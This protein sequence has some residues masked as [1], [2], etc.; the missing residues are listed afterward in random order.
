MRLPVLAAVAAAL[1]VTGVAGAAV[2]GVNDDAAKDTAQVGWL[3]PTLAGEGL[4]ESTLTLRWD[5]A[6]PAA[7]PDQAAV[8]RAVAAAAANGASVELDLFP[9]HSMAFT[10]GAKCASTTDPQGCG[11]TAQIQSFAVWAGQVA[12]AFPTVHQ[13]VVMNEC[14]QPLFVNPQFDATG[15]N[16]SAQIC[17]RA[18]AAAYDALKGVSSQNVVW[19]VGLSPRG[20]DNPNAASNVS[21]SPTKFLADLGAWYKASGRTRPLMD[22]LDFHPYPIPQSLPFATGYAGTTSA[23]VSNLPRIYQ[24]F[25]DAFN[26]SPQRTIG[27]QT[28]GG[29]P[30]SL[31]E[32]GIQTDSTGSPGY[33][34]TETAANAAG[35]VLGATATE[36]YQ[37]SWYSQMLQYVACDPN[38]TQV[39]IYHL[40]DESAL[41]GWQSGLF[42]VDHTPKASASM[43]HDWVA[44]TG[45]ACLG[46]LH[47]WTPPGVAAAA[48]TSPPPIVSRAHVVVASAGRIRIFD[49]SSHVLRRVLA[50]FGTAYTGAISL[51]LGDVNHDGVSDIAAGQGPVVKVLNGKSGGTLATYATSF[52]PGVSVALGDVTGD[53]RADLVVGSGAG[54]PAQV[55]V[56]DAKTHKLLETLT[57]FGAA[58]KGGVS[59]AAADLNGDGKADVIAG[60][61]AG[62]KAQIV[63]FSGATSTVLETLAPFSPTFTGGVAVA[64]ADTNQDGKTDVVAATGSGTASV[65]RVF[66][67]ATNARLLSFGPFGAIIHR[68]RLR[69]G[70]EG[71]DRRGHGVRR[72]LAGPHVRRQDRRSELELDRCDWI[73]RRDGRCS[74]LLSRGSKCQNGHERRQRTPHARSLWP[75]ALHACMRSGESARIDEIETPEGDGLVRVSTSALNPIDISIGSGR[76]YGGSP[77]TPYVI[78]S[79]VVGT[80]G[81]GRRVWVRGRQLMAEVVKPETGHW[82]FDIPDGVGD[83]T[84]LGC[85]IA[86]LTAWLAV[87]WRAPVRPDDTVLVLGAS[88]T[89]GSVAVQ[90]A[91]LL[92]AKHVIGAARR[93]DLIPSAA[94]EVFDLGT[95][96][97]MPPASLIVDA[98]WGEPLERAFAA[99]PVGVRI[100]NLGQSAG[101]GSTL[102]SGWVRG[103]VADILGHSLFALSPE[104]AAAGYRELCEHARDGAINFETEIFGLGD[105]AEAWAK[106]ASGSPGRKIVV[107]L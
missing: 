94:D 37:S 85:G 58:F 72:Q 53:G 32:V 87:S 82:V 70:R 75:C 80:T 18:L 50:P 92:G 79:E 63:A 81:D 26:G 67:G 59:V 30:V 105:I 55:K 65:I 44:S 40:L 9:L 88:G 16:Q 11:N 4:T 19:G 83:A 47:P 3:Y 57:P 6:A 74:S 73:D 15:A 27:Q 60:T 76:F 95:D 13:Y 29:L 54:A 106:Q 28:G 24:A 41:S 39:D 61:G 107:E 33:V 46:A 5:E 25:Y 14:N 69:L 99:A 98:L 21:T 78:G 77:P 36:D 35:G 90:S 52:R 93:T 22:G 100:V 102:Q 91:K 68:G 34:G 8:T 97:P 96:G 51:A 104:I 49:A 38:I 2:I 42:Y 45:G 20:N 31:N 66:S 84:A 48:S 71:H 12:A 56:Y 10:G 62:A 17:G 23:S 101:P 64:A 7:V 103:K 86:G 89:L 1:L 43:V